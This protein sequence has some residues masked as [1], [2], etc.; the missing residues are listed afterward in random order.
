MEI[1]LCKSICICHRG[2]SIV[3]IDTFLHKLATNNHT[4]LVLIGKEIIVVNRR[5]SVLTQ[6]AGIGLTLHPSF[7]S[8]P[9]VPF[10]MWHRFSR[11]IASIHWALLWLLTAW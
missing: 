3:E 9:N 11:F 5:S 10:L 4:S 1:H 6:S 8:S 7:H 2:E